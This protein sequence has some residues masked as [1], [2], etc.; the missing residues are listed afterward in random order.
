[1]SRPITPAHLLE[2]F[3]GHTPFALI[4]VRE[5]GEYNASHIPRS[6]LM[7][8]RMLEFDLTAAVP[9][10]TTLVVLCDDDGQRVARAVET[11]E[12]MGY[13]NVAWLEG[14]VNRWMSL[15]HPT[16]W[17][18]NVP[19]KDF[20]EKMEVVHHV[21]EIDAMELHA[22]MERG[23]KMVILDTRT[24]EEYRRFCIPGG[25]SLPGGE[26]ALRITDVTADLDPD[27]TV[28]QLCRPDTQHHRDPSPPAHGTGSAGGRPQKRNIRLGARG[29]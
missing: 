12:Q 5:P 21:P 23:D 28:D 11:V 19:S 16:E 10:P 4:D 22:R 27:T 24:P 3:D 25:R 6:S 1:M 13:S 9:H 8:R 15:D 7:P 29:L 20:G 18:V 2:L 26:L 14:G 17:G